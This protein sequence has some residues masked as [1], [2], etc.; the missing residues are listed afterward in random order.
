MSTIIHSDC[1]ENFLPVSG[2]S[3]LLG[4]KGACQLASVS[5][6]KT[7]YHIR[8]SQR[9]YHIL[10][11]T[12]SGRGKIT[13]GE[14]IKYCTPGSFLCLPAAVSYDMILDDTHWNVV[15]FHL[16]DVR[17][18]KI[19]KTQNV[20]LRPSEIG[21]KLK[22]LMNMYLDETLIPNPNKTDCA[23]LLA[24]LMLKLIDRE[25]GATSGNNQL[26]ERLDSCWRKVSESLEKD[27]TLKSISKQSKFSERHFIRV[28]K[29]VYGKTPSQLLSE[30]KCQRICELLKNP[31]NT[32]ERIAADVGYQSA[33]ILSNAFKRT[34]GVRPTNY[35][36]AL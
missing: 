17:R 23:D 21:P 12:F 29:E 25:L 6:L 31:D 33:Y 22:D 20:I 28:C 3:T 18:W 27:W 19:I 11:Y 35:R 30:A 15:L 13:I 34:I 10:F 9:N 16:S 32:L 2:A 4:N 1:K 5:Y 7:G 26:R 8:R 24:E 14:E 36:R